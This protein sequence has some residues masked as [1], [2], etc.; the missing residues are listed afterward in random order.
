[1][2][3]CVCVEGL[4]LSPVGLPMCAHFSRAVVFFTE[5]LSFSVYL[6]TREELNITLW[7][8]KMCFMETCLIIS[9]DSFSAHVSLRSWRTDLW[10]FH[11]SL[12]QFTFI[13][14]CFTS[15]FFT[16]MFAS[17]PFPHVT[18]NSFKTLSLTLARCLWCF[19]SLTLIFYLF[20]FKTFC[21]N[22]QEPDSLV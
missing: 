21:F 8:K 4:F 11:R 13:F 16:W 22:H 1:M 20:C 19:W 3:L 15:S 9:F 12:L 7:K 6:V 5:R 17:C 14:W 10:A 18:Q 2:I